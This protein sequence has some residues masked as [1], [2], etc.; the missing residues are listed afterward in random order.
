MADISITAA[1]VSK[2]SGAQNTGVAGGTITA[3]QS[4]YLDPS[5]NTIKLADAIT[6]ATTAACVGIALNGAS[7]GQPLTYQTS[8]N[9]NIGATLTIGA[10]YIL[11]G[12]NAGG[13]APVADLTSTWF[14]VVLGIAQTAGILTIVNAANSP[15]T[16]HA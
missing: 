6:S 16:A 1:S 13:V 7:T 12:A 4:V 11:S 2:A 14:P 9:I 8:G 15:Q 3:G 5:S 10:V